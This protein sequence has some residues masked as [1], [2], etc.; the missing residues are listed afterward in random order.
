MA[1]P[2][3]AIAAELAA[4]TAPADRVFVFGSEPEVLFGARRVSASRYIFLFPVFNTFRD[5][6]ERQASV[7]AEV[8][9]ARPAAI[10]WLPL[11]SFYGRGRPQRLTE[12]TTA[13]INEHYRLA[14]FVVADAA[15][16]STIERV[17]PD[18]EGPAE[19]GELEPW[20][21]LFVR[22]PN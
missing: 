11:Q 22:A 17:A 8:E 20:A 10:V 2:R 6:A 5:V 1:P 21:M 12:W 19:L 16:R 13:Y 15:G 9:S 4:N 3:S 18:A 7:I 14:A